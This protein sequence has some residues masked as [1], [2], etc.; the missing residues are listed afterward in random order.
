MNLRLFFYLLPVIFLHANGQEA[1]LLRFPAIY[2]N[3]VVFTY[4]GDLYTVDRAGGQ[5]RRLTSDVGFETFARFSP[6]G[7]TIAFTGQYDGNTEVYTI[8]AEGG[9]PRRVTYTATLGRDDITDRM[10][11]NNIVM[12]WQDNEHIIYRSRKKTFN[13]FVGQLFVADVNGGLSG[14]LPLPAGGFCSY[15]PDRKQL[16]YN[17]VFREF[18]TW[19]Y[20]KG[21]MADDIWIYDF[22]TKKVEDI[23]N[24][25]A[26]DIEP[27]WAGD[28]IYFLSDRDRTMNLF[29]YDLA[30][31]QVRKITNYKDYDIK[32]P[33]LG[34]NAIV[35]EQAGYLNVMDL[36]TEKVSRIEVQIHSDELYSR[37]ELVDASHFIQNAALGPDGNR[38]VLIARGDV[39]TV[40]AEKGITRDISR[41]SGVHERNA[42]WSPDG[43]HVAFISDSTGEDEIYLQV[44]DGQ[45][46][47]VRVTSGGDVYKYELAWSPDSKKIVWGDKKMRIQY[48]DLDSK[49]ISVFDSSGLREM[50][51]YSWSP[52]SKWISYTRNGHSQVD[53]IWLYNIGS[54]KKIKVTDEWY[55]SGSPVFSPD[56]KYLYFQSAR[57]FNPT[58]SNVEFEIAYLNV[59]K[60][61]ILPLSKATANPFAPVNNE[62]AVKGEAAGEK[63]GGE[64][65]KKEPSKDVVIDEDNLSD[66]I[67]A[68]SAEPGNYNELSAVEGKLY[69]LRRSDPDHKSSL[70]VVDL[71]ENKETVLGEVDWFDISADGRKMLLRR[72]N[73]RYVIDL[74]G[75]RLDLK[76]PPLNTSDMKIPVNKKEEWM[77]IFNESWR[78]MRDFFYSPIMNGADWKAVHDKY[79]VLVPFVNHRADLDYI[80]G[81]MIGEISSGHTYTGG[82]DFPTHERISM[83]LLGAELSRDASG[84]FRIDRILEGANYDASLRSPLTEL[85]VNVHTGDYITSVNGVATTTVNDIYS[86]LVNTAGRQVELGING[87]PSADGAHKAIVIPIASEEPLY[88]Y[89]WV[90]HNIHYVDSV[91]GGKI[92]YLH[93]PDMGVEG[94]NEFIKHFYPQITKK[95]LIIDDRGNGG[96]FVS[97]LVAERLAKQLVYFELQRNAKEGLPNPAMHLGPK[98]CLINQYSAS[99][100]DIFPYRFRKYQLGKLIGKRTWGGVVGIRGS[101]PFVDGG[102]LT[103]PEFAPFLEGG[104]VIEGHGVDPDIE[105]DNDPAREYAGIDDQLNAAV[106][107]LLEELKTNEQKVPAIPTFP[108]KT[109]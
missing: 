53:E 51:D 38:V 20:Y 67:L 107:Q 76:D 40:P 43:K 36:A 12:T 93:I 35:F 39:F 69:Y 61:Y 37:T 56:G 79:A 55:D 70:A 80:L 78:Q 94:L 104:F 88:Y 34:N 31:K 19:K 106:A 5:A 97:P 100:G 10:G 66:R 26:Q 98:V 95:A 33:S 46:P 8:P 4:A 52:D 68:L 96:G 62:V 84:Y 45:H 30:T 90:E 50:R 92:G 75:G 27:M 18:R 25:P 7:K 17:R 71:K 102:M 89:G 60:L 59:A 48:V 3:Q 63:Q 23:T 65:E 64:K 109:K 21:G 14:E 86:L 1:R 15:S 77:Q 99:D 82:G 16:A 22:A 28:K 6:D 72:G 101:L 32:F 54:G 74:P 73:S 2:N 83:G 9:S 29:C 57:E 103:K 24:N 105:V 44:P 41:T 58:F 85:G 11:P 81:E 49:K 42:V 87:R 47:P 91:S 13:D 108:D